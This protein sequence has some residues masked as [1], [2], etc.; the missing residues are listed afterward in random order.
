MLTLIGLL[1]A[2][3]WYYI[4]LPAVNIHSASFWFFVMG[5]IVVC[6][7]IYILKKAGRGVITVAQDGNPL[8]FNLNISS[9]G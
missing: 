1:V 7:G 4:Y 9:E 2:G 5:L 3:L 6:M 8:H